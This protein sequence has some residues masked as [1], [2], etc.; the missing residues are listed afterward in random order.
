MWLRTDERED[1][2]VS[3]LQCVNL[4]R[5]AATQPRLWKW[6]ILSLHNALQGAMACHLS[7]TAQFGALDKKNLKAHLA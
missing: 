1:V 4:L 2:A 6:A 7:G 5:E 3:L